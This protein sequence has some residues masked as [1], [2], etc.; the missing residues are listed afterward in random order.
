[1][2]RS[3]YAERAWKPIRKQVLE[4]DRQRCQIGA[5]G[6]TGTATH[7]D[8]IVPLSRGGA[9]FDPSNLRA[10]CQTCNLSRGD[11]RRGSGR[12][13]S[14]R[15]GWRSAPTWITLVVGPPGAG[16]STLVE[17]RATPGDLV[18]DFDRLAQ[19]L[20]SPVSHDH[21][22]ATV[23]AAKAARGAVLSRLRR[24]EVSAARAWIISSNADAESMFP[25]HDIELVDPGEA[26]VRRRAVEAGRPDRW[27]QLIG[28]WYRRRGGEVDVGPSRAW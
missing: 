6:C 20:G 15:D 23:E 22:A 12:G 21:D 3:A 24:G 10:A 17:R 28:D 4:R 7:V 18:V 8:H 1:M 25:Y 11:G 19:S 5:P 26:E 2:A 13:G 27:L 16:K 14:V 9:R